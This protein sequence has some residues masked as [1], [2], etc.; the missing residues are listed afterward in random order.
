[1]ETDIQAAAYVQK[2]TAGGRQHSDRQVG[3]QV[4]RAAGTQAFRQRD[5]ETDRERDRQG[6]RETD[7]QAAARRQKRTQGGRHA[8]TDR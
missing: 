3:G 8:V 7:I 4:Q 5:V 2:S 6:E 1:M